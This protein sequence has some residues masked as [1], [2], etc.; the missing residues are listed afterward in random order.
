MHTQFSQ[1]EIG[2][3]IEGNWKGTNTW[4]Q[5]QVKDITPE[6][7]FVHY[8]DGDQ[9]L[10]TQPQFIRKIIPINPNISHSLK[11]GEIIEA[12]WKNRGHWY[13]GTI[14]NIYKGLVFIQFQDGDKEW[15]NDFSRIR[16]AKVWTNEDRLNRL[17]TI[18]DMSF[19]VPILTVANLVDLSVKDL[20]N[21]VLDNSDRFSYIRILEE[22]FKNI[23]Q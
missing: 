5:G 23:Q 20:L 16:F 14:G 17:E 12:N 18:F 3:I 8:I 22:S 19:S 2:D 13:R 1:F 4:Y 9:E 6:G 7:V 21:L 10:I 11:I 15:I